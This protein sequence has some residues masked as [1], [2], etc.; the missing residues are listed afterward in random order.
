MRKKIDYFH[1][2]IL[3]NKNN[4]KMLG[5]AIENSLKVSLNQF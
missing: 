3:K 1:I 2:S 5:I 4:N